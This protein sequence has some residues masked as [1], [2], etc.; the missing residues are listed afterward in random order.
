MLLI[1]F[2]YPEPVPRIVG[3]G[4]REEP[5]PSET[6]WWTST[7]IAFRHSDTPYIP[8]GY[9]HWDRDKREI[10]TTGDE[11]DQERPLIIV[12]IKCRPTTRLAAQLFE[13]NYSRAVK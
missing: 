3:E 9:L 13:R 1:P 12:N 2:N 8:V 10:S 6:W 5:M 11:Q 4:V 7:K